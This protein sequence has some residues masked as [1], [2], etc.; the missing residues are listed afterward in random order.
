M[1]VPADG[2]QA[3]LPEKKTHLTISEAL[4][5]VLGGN[6]EYPKDMAEALGAA[7]AAFQEEFTP[8]VVYNIFSG[9]QEQGLTDWQSTV[10]E[11]KY[12]S[13]KWMEV[14]LSQIGH[15]KMKEGNV[16]A[17][18][19]HF[20]AA[21]RRSQ[22]ADSLQRLQ[23]GSLMTAETPWYLETGSHIQMVNAI[24]GHSF[25]KS[26][27]RNATLATPR[28]GVPRQ[29]P[30]RGGAAARGGTRGGKEVGEIEEDERSDTQKHGKGVLA[31]HH[32]YRQA[33]A[34]A[35]ATG[36][37]CMAGVD[38]AAAEVAAN[39][40]S[41]GN[42][43]ESIVVN[44]SGFVLHSYQRQLLRDL[45]PMSSKCPPPDRISANVSAKE[46]F[47]K[48]IFMNRPFIVEAGSADHWPAFKR[49]TRQGLY[50]HYGNVEV[51]VATKPLPK[52]P[53]SRQDPSWKGS[54]D[55]ETMRM[56]EFLDAVL[57][58]QLDPATHGNLT[59]PDRRYVFNTVS[60]RMAD[61]IADPKQLN[62]ARS[63]QFFRSANA[64][65][66]GF[67]EWI[68]GPALSGAH[69]HAHLAAW[70]VVV[71]GRKRWVLAPYGEFK[72]PKDSRPA[73]YWFTEELP[74][75]QAEDE[76]RFM[77]FEQAPGELVYVPDHWYHAVIN[78]EPTVGASKQLGGSIWL[79]G[80]PDFAFGR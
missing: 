49:W 15:R 58:S 1:N 21:M 25:M 39:L 55:V 56:A 9:G 80:L 59:Y 12:Q 52:N 72:P 22:H 13:T 60:G 35:S 71:S 17:A 51:N 68:V 16:D 10:L 11:M 19:S 79:E 75:L 64:H 54:P 63:K 50:T 65:P 69:I 40:Y 30:P 4:D 37:L 34:V 73:Y 44:N 18:V 74:L 29:P 46:V 24:L 78:T 41:E 6:L 38:K 2:T 62:Y 7:N 3:T 43:P 23:V 20:Q 66:D 76:C 67:L 45:P 47:E 33:D 61:D 31:A 53:G 70:N 5:L 26:A 36:T 42:S 28:S 14:V 32:V 77:E 57:P 48:Y 27:A 8:Q